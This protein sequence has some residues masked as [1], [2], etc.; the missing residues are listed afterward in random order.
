MLRRC[1]GPSRYGALKLNSGARIIYIISHMF[2]TLPP[3]IVRHIVDMY[4]DIV[5]H[6]YM[7][8]RTINKQ[9]YECIGTAREYIRN[10][11]I[12][13][14]MDNACNT[15]FSTVPTK[16]NR[17]SYDGFISCL[18]EQ[19]LNYIPPAHVHIYLKHKHLPILVKVINNDFRHYMHANF[20]VAN[21]H[22]CVG[23]SVDA[24]NIHR[25]PD[26]IV[27]TAITPDDTPVLRNHLWVKSF[28][29]E[30]FIELHNYITARRC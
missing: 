29:N 20:K 9:I 25:I 1:P 10:H 28:I 22:I 6:K 8:L 13:N 5:G 18:H 19:L 2:S 12:T 30:Y 11:C 26:G 14:V 7:P 3:E 23:D 4:I 16:N 15:V 21:L 17:I 27:I 24:F